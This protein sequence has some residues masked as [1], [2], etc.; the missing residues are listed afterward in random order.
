VYFSG[1]MVRLMLVLA[2]IAC[3]LS[4]IAVSEILT[5]YSL[6]ITSKPSKFKNGQPNLQYSK[7]I[8]IFILMGTTILLIFYAQ[9]C[10]TI[11]SQAYSSPSV[12]LA[13][14]RPDGSKVIFDDY[15]DAYWW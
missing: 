8:G 10:I 12:V 13:S 5:T 14:Y 15:R 2:P 4:S 9:H 1:V 11:T 7:S 6:Y 3:V